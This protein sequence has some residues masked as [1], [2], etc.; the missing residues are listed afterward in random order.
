[1]P[2][3]PDG[4]ADCSESGVY[5]KILICVGAPRCMRTKE[6]VRQAQLDDCVWCRREWQYRDSGDGI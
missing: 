5:K 3:T 6:N 4:H 2:R 1:M